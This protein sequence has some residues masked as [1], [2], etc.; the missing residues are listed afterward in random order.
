LIN[1]RKSHGHRTWCRRARAVPP[2]ACLPGWRLGPL[3][4]VL[5]RIWPY[6]E[7]IQTNNGRQK[8]SARH[9]TLSHDGILTNGFLCIDRGTLEMQIAV[10]REQIA[11]SRARAIGIHFIC[12]F[13]LL[14]FLYTFSTAVVY[15]RVLSFYLRKFSSRGCVHLGTSGTTLQ[16]LQLYETAVCTPRSTSKQVLEYL[17]LGTAV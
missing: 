17:N 1:P 15:T 13:T 2:W 6:L 11:V 9:I 4:R 14:T 8:Y 16:Y 3:H 12:T 7:K 10:S 5:P